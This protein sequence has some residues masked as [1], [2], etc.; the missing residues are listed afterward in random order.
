MNTVTQEKI[1][2]LILH[3]KFEVFHRVHEKQCLV[4]AK[5]PNGFTVVG[6]SACVDPVNYDETI[7]E[8][9]AKEHIKKRL[10]ELEGYSLQRDIYREKGLKQ[11]SEAFE[12]MRNCY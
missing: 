7:G 4:V 8:E 11:L 3:S 10:W 1:D 6:E 5:L 2:T 9:L 12:G